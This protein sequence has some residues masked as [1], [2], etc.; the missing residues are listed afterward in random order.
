VEWELPRKPIKEDD[1]RKGGW[2]QRF[3]EGVVEIDALAARQPGRLGQLVRERVE[4]LQD[5]SLRHRMEEAA[6]EAD[7]QVSTAVEDVTARHRGGAQQTVSEYN[8][9]AERYRERLEALSAEFEGE[10]GHLRER[11]REQQE[12][13]EAEVNALEIELP[14][15]PE[16]ESPEDPLEDQWMYDSARD[17]TWQTELF[18]RAQKRD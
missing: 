3:G 16:A 5:P 12:A 8:E 6:A 10:V 11:F 7:R 4:S 1:R 18:R 17:F 2:E 13:F 9:V 15:P 14:E